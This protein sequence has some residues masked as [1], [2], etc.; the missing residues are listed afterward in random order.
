VKWLAIVGIWTGAMLLWASTYLGYPDFRLLGVVYPIGLWAV[1][2]A[3]ILVAGLVSRR[4]RRRRGQE[5][6]P[7]PGVACAVDRLPSPTSAYSAYSPSIRRGEA[8]K[9][10]FKWYLISLAIWTIVAFL[11]WFVGCG[12]ND[13]DGGEDGLGAVLAVIVWIFGAVILM[14]VVAIVIEARRPPPAGPRLVCTNCEATLFAQ[15][16]SGNDTYKCRACGQAT[17]GRMSDDGPPS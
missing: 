4:R 17:A 11:G 9:A 7:T 8:G 3:V 14:L 5:G 15:W 6:P 12:I 1:G 2:M 13:C 10:I 16:R